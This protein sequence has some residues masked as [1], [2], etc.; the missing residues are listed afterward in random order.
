[1]VNKWMQKAIDTGPP[2]FKR[3]AEYVTE[4]MPEVTLPVLRDMFKHNASVA[5]YQAHQ[6]RLHE[7]IGGVM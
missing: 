4:A 3:Y 5:E 7:K 1:M 6:E 2:E